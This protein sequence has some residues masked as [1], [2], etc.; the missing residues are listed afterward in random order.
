M[1]GRAAA[2]AACLV[3]GACDPGDGTRVEVERELPPDASPPIRAPVQSIRGQ[4]DSAVVTY[5]TG[6]PACFALARVEVTYRVDEI[7]FEVFH[8]RTATPDTACTQEA[9]TATVRVPLS[10]AIGG[11]DLVIK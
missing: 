10:E 11:R 8:S 9:V 6:V 1:T 5:V 3:L 4:S 7:A 2:L